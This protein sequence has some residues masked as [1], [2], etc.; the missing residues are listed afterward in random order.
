MLGQKWAELPSRET[1]SPYHIKEMTPV[2]LRLKPYTARTLRR[3]LIWPSLAPT[4]A[5]PEV[6][7]SN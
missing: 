6:N 7:E 2:W 4:E 5:A 3:L 1:K